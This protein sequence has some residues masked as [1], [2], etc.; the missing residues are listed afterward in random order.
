[1]FV[2]WYQSVFV[3]VFLGDLPSAKSTRNMYMYI[4]RQNNYWCNRPTVY[5]VCVYSNASSFLIY[6]DIKNPAVRVL[7]N[8]LFSFINLFANPFHILIVRR[9][10]RVVE[11]CLKL[12]SKG[13]EGI[14]VYWSWKSAT[15]LRNND[16]QS[17]HTIHIIL[18]ESLYTGC[19]TLTYFLY[20]H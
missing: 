7:H 14:Q 8:A 3:V 4:K 16:R 1:M 2:P 5:C 10:L 13:Y 18:I 12:Y 20:Y 6:N 17:S 19:I 11:S 15:S 9:K